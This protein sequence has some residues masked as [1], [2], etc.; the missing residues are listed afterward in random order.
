MTRLASTDWADNMLNEDIK[1]MTAPLLSQWNGQPVVQE[2]FKE[3]QIEDLL[4]RDPIQIDIK[5]VAS[6]LEGKRVLITGAA[7]SI[8]SEIMALRRKTFIYY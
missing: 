3:I 2:Q 7:G 8:G 1:L 5:K 4:Q 6:H